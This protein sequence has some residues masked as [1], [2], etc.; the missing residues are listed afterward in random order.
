MAIMTAM[1]TITTENMA[2]IVVAMM[3]SIMIVKTITMI[4][5]TVQ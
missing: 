5:I 3:I 4:T 1:T 2:I